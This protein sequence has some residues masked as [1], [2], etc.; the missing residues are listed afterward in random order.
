MDSNPHCLQL[1]VTLTPA[2][3]VIPGHRAPAGGLAFCVAR[4]HPGG[5]PPARRH[6]HR[7]F[8]AGGRQVLSHADAA[9][10]SG[11][12]VAEAGGPG[13]RPA[14]SGRSA[15]KRGRRLVRS[16]RAILRQ[17]GLPAGPPRRHDR[18]TGPRPRPPGP[19]WTGVCGAALPRPP[20]TPHRSTA[21]LPPRTG[22]EGR[23]AAGTG[24]TGPRAPIS[25]LLPA[26]PGV[27]P[28]RPVA[29]AR[30]AARASAVSGLA[31]LCAL[32]LDLAI[33]PMTLLT[34]SWSVGPSWPALR[35]MAA[36]AALCS[37]MLATESLHSSASSSR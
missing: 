35:W 37:R 17:A 14:P 22:A 23:P 26:T 19:S 11:E 9:A 1:P 7:Q 3:L 21:T 10:V 32:A 28:F 34:P 5:F 30:T 4:R 13:R 36:R 6:Q 27:F 25:G 8:H 15:W 12:A 16:G 18:C 2:F 29:V 20:G 31:Y 24:G 33:P